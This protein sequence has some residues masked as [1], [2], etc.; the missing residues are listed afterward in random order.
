MV[1]LHLILFEAWWILNERTFYCLIFSLFERGSWP[2]KN[3]KIHQAGESSPN[4]IFAVVNLDP[5]I[6]G[7]RWIQGRSQPHSPGW[8]R[9]PLS[10]FFTQV[11]TN[12]SYF[13][14]NNLFFSSFW[15]Y[16]WATRPPGKALATP[17]GELMVNPDLTILLKKVNRGEDLRW[18]GSRFPLTR[19]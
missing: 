11:S 9:V 2:W 7:K 1:N 10:S 12:L 14:S 19:A 15:P 3:N 18:I 16:G 13:S 6:L 4:F 5:I 17:L 8:A